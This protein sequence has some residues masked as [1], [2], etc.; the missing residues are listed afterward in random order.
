MCQH[1][2]NTPVKKPSGI[3]F[4]IPAVSTDSPEEGTWL[5]DDNG[6]KWFNAF[7]DESV[8]LGQRHTEIAEW[9]SLDPA[10]VEM[11]WVP[12]DQGAGCFRLTYNCNKK[13]G[14]SAFETDDWVPDSSFKDGQGK[15]DCM[16]TQKAAYAKYCYDVQMFYMPG[17]QTTGEYAPTVHVFILALCC[18]LHGTLLPAAFCTV[19]SGKVPV[20][21]A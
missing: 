19:S 11:K 5:R 1:S 6:E 13:W 4:V 17:E 16:V 8:C 14:A 18:S 2:V 7:A 10:D 15:D 21:Q 20:K 12:W 9:C 3:K